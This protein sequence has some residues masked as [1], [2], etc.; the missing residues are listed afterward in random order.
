[1]TTYWENLNQRKRRLK[2]FEA[3]WAR[4][5]DQ[6]PGWATNEEDKRFQKLLY[7]WLRFHEAMLVEEIV[8]ET[9]KYLR[10]NPGCRERG[11]YA[12]VLVDEYQDMN[13]AEQSLIDLL[14]ENGTLTILGDADQS[15]YEA[16][17]YAHPEGITE[18][19]ETPRGQ[20]THDI[21]LDICR[22]CPTRVVSLANEL[23]QHN[24]NRTKQ[25][26]K[27]LRTNGDG[28]IHVVQWQTVDAEAEGIARF[29]SGRIESGAFAPGEVLV[30]SPFRKLG[31]LIRDRLVE[32]L[33]AGAAHSFFHEEF[34]DGNP[35]RQDDNKAQEAFTLLRL[36]VNPNDR[37]ALRCWLGFGDGELCFTEYQRLRSYGQGN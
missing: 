2:A 24:Q 17:R 22:R 1:M 3:A 19:H 35:K 4:E 34:L 31:Y 37:V 28:E 14:N 7:E 10:N 33:G 18:F 16:F 21:P 23:I 5:Q 32:Y 20:G 12:H 6:Q 26:L 11:R 25:T 8:P 13:R 36:A 29:I 15:I 27:P 30:L 9:L